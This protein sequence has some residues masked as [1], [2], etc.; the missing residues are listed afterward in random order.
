MRPSRPAGK[1][2]HARPPSSHSLPGWPN[3]P[4]SPARTL[5]RSSLETAHT[6]RGVRVE[7]AELKARL[8]Q[9]NDDAKARSTAAER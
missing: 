1:R 8:G 9:R 4:G 2:P 7:L 5:R 6:L 3:L